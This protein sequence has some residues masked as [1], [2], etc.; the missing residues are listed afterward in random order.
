MKA[1]ET[2]PFFPK[3]ASGRPAGSGARSGKRILQALVSLLFLG[4][5]LWRLDLDVLLQNAA[6]A[7]LGYLIPWI[8][9][10]YA[11]V[12]FLWAVGLHALLYPIAPAPLAQ[13]FS[14][15]VKLNVL[16]TVIP[17]RLGDVGILYLLQGRY[18][19]G[20]TSAV[21]VVDKTITL[22]INTVLSS[23]AL[24][25]FFSGM[26]ALVLL[27]VLTSLAAAFLLVVLKTP[28]RV[29][30]MPLLARAVEALKGARF[31]LVRML[32][33][34]GPL[35]VNAGT[36]LLRLLLAGVSFQ[37]ILHWF[38]APASL[39]DVV[40]I[41]SLA[42]LA[43][44]LPLTIM[45]IGIS[46]AVM[47]SLFDRIHV[48]PEAVLAASLYGRAIHLL[49]VSTLYLFWMGKRARERTG[50]PRSKEDEGP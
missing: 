50:A 35:A 2:H 46:E 34:P 6:E 33:N 44:F 38:H 40:L 3:R 47:V 10:Y 11:A 49:L 18:T 20:Q 37:V 36:T 4:V 17:G 13:V 9:V 21:F 41:Q 28:A 32:G 42:Q 26:T 39:K 12:V 45:G 29:L 22:L 48:S 15:S 30:K 8:F 16:A 19:Y 25:V 23:L 27:S 31:E 1:P 7:P 24:W 43:C 14:A 5:I